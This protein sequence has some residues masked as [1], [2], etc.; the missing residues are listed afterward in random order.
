MYQP[1]EADYGVQ[2]VPGYAA[3]AV[4]VVPDAA[5]QEG[6]TRS[7]V[8]SKAE[9]PAAEVLCLP[10]G[11]PQESRAFEPEITV[12]AAVVVAVVVVGE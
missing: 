4:C 5:L 11:D 12:A 2:E 6:E 10:E 9:V 7:A 1:E 3:D 8:H